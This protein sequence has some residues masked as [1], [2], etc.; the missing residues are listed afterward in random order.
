M[1]PVVKGIE[2]T[3]RSML[4]YSGIMVLISL[5]L[6]PIAGMGWVYMLAAVATGGWFLW[7]TFRVRLDPS[8]AMKLFTASTVYLSVVFAAV[9]V[10]V[11]VR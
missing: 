3:T 1:L 11:L 5:M 9:V 4:T 10:D 8:R 2:A 6:V 7:E